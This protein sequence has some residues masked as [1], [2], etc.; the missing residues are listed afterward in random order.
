MVTVIVETPAGTVHC[1]VV[2]A[3]PKLTVQV[4]ASHERCGVGRRRC[5]VDHSGR[6]HAQRGGDDQHGER[7]TTG[8]VIGNDNVHLRLS[9]EQRSIRHA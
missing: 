5:G 2:P 1:W 7:A 9:F 3:V 6:E 4:V 8:P